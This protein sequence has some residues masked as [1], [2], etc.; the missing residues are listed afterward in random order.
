MKE[1]IKFFPIKYKRSIESPARN[2]SGGFSGRPSLPF[3]RGELNI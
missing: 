1:V 2:P 3:S